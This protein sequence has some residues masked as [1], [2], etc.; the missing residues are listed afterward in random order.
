MSGPGLLGLAFD[1][2]GDTFLFGFLLQLFVGL[3]AG[4]KVLTA[5]GVTDVFN[6][7]IDPIMRQKKNLEMLWQLKNVRKLPLGQNFASELFVNN[8]ADS[9]L[10][11]I[12][13]TSSFTVVKLVWHAL[14]EGTISLDINDIALLVNFQEGRERLDSVLS[15]VLLEQMTG[16]TPVSF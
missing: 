13:D 5:L 4:Q 12:E 8:D 9:M 3:D 1:N 11:N 16:S 10:R 6:S 7:D 2:N 15:E 14:L